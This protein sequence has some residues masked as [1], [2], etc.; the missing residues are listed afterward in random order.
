MTKRR[1]LNVT[2]TKKQ[3]NMLPYVQLGDGT[4]QAIGPTT[5]PSA[6]GGAYIF[7][8]SARTF[9]N[10]G[11]TPMARNSQTTYVRGFKEKISMRMSDGAGWR[12]RRIVFA[13]KGLGTANT[14]RPYLDTSSGYARVMTRIS[15]STFYDN[16]VAILFKGTYN[17]DWSNPYTAKV[18]T[19]RVTLLSD[20]SRTI[21]NGNTSPRYLK[22]QQWYPIN[23]NIVYGDE[24]AGGLVT[25]NLYSTTSKAGIGD[26]YVLD[27]FDCAEGTANAH[28]LIVDPECTYYWHEK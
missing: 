3:D 4:G 24:E 26:I 25:G 10:T 28:T 14:G 27:F 9:D 1:I 19:Q 22:H 23:K 11:N 18:D 20:K 2:S 8:P 16:L 5:V 7:S 13:A 12:W 21:G 17:V 15:G 6:G